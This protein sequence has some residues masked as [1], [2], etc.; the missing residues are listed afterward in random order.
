MIKDRKLF[1]SKRKPFSE[2]THSLKF[3]KKG[4][5]SKITL[6]EPYSHPTLETS[7]VDGQNKDTPDTKATIWDICNSIS[8]LHKIFSG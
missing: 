3:L 7:S 5:S 1:P 6:S 8:Q 2:G 4:Q